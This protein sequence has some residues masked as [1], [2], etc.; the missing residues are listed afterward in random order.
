MTRLNISFLK[1]LSLILN[2]TLLFGGQ[3]GG[4][5]TQ[6]SGKQT[7][8]FVS[9]ILLVYSHAENKTKVK[10]GAKAKNIAGKI[11]PVLQSKARAYD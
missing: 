8:L 7:F 4:G 1:L 10:I 5:K 6:T 11:S 9:Y 3:E 2:C